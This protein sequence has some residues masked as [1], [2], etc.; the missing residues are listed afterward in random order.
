MD[1]NK[2]TVGIITQ[3][4]PTI[5]FGFEG[6][7]YSRNEIDQFSNERFTTFKEKTSYDVK[8]AILLEFM[9]IGRLLKDY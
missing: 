8:T 2:I 9:D 7:V 1:D 6:G 5:Q 4:P 3:T